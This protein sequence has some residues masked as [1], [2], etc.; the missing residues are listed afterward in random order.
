LRFLID[1]RAV[2]RII[3]E[4]KALNWIAQS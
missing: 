1:Y 2:P 4:L 3:E